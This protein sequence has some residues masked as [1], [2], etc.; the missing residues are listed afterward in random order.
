MPTFQTRTHIEADAATVWA[1]LI[2]TD[3]WTAWDDKLE[4]VEGGLDRNGQV[5][6]R[7]VDV[8]RP[9]KLKVS[10]WEPPNRLVLTGGMP[11]GLFTGTR[12][13][14][15]QADGTATDFEMTERYTGPLTGVFSRSIPDLQPSFDAFAAGLKAAA[16]AQ[17]QQPND[18]ATTA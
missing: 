3:Q 7:V 15:L 1:T 11:L 14:R 13:Y 10:S 2:R 9:F 18:P 16:E 5:T 17:Q 4:H 6:I 12:T 8:A